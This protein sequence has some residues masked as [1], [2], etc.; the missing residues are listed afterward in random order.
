MM[1]N[2]FKRKILVV[3]IV[4][5]LF[6]K[7]DFVLAQFGSVDPPSFLQGLGG[8]SVEG[9]PVLINIILRTLIVGAGIFSI[10]N[11][12]LAGYG[13]ISSGGDPKRIQDAQSRITYSV[14][15]LVVAAGAFVIAGAIGFLLF[16]NPTYLLRVRIFTP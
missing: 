2:N 13:Y 11:F 5:L 7:T 12:I 9:L 3:L 6:L 10:F 15:G 14:I 4:T 16:G 1:K 8:G